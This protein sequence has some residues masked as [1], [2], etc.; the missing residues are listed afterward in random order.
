MADIATLDE[1]TKIQISI[2]FLFGCS[3]EEIAKKN[4][5]SMAVFYDVLDSQRISEAEQL[6]PRPLI[7]LQHTQKVKKTPGRRPVIPALAIARRNSNIVSHN[8]IEFTLGNTTYGL[9]TCKKCGLP[10]TVILHTSKQDLIHDCRL[11]AE[12]QEARKK[13]GSTL[14]IIQNGKS[15]RVK[16]SQARID[17]NLSYFRYF[18]DRDKALDAAMEIRDFLLGHKVVKEALVRNSL[19]KS[20]KLAGGNNT[21][22]PGIT[23]SLRTIQGEKYLHAHAKTNYG[24]K[25]QSTTRA[26]IKYSPFEALVEALNWRREI[27]GE[28]PV[29]SV[30]SLLD[31]KLLLKW[32]NEKDEAME[33]LLKT[34][35]GKDFHSWLNHTEPDVQ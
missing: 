14:H 25:R 1:K 21:G 3:P 9:G 23:V 2:D 10:A 26:F 13:N 31:K 35:D 33:V 5:I 4:G 30:K 19:E 16:I 32:L 11:G 18:N 28:K 8:G 17:I 6:E 34:Q 15:W 20:N 29:L 12:A 22:L 7:T 27:L 24:K